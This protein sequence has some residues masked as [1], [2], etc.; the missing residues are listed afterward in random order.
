LKYLALIFWP[1]SLLFSL[2]NPFDA[3]TFHNREM[4]KYEMK[5]RKQD[6]FQ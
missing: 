6:L 3:K 4:E 1:G 5:R 2:S